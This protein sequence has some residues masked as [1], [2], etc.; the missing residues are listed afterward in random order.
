MNSQL[1]SRQ[2]IDYLVSRW[3]A[4]PRGGGK[5][6]LRHEVVQASVVASVPSVFTHAVAI[7]SSADF[8]ARGLEPSKQLPQRSPTLPRAADNRMKSAFQK[9]KSSV[10]RNRKM[11]V[12]TGAVLLSTAAVTAVAFGSI[13]ATQSN[14]SVR[15]RIIP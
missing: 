15:I 5:D 13:A 4:E 7:D 1:V 11:K 10:D 2:K 6:R 3:W 14:L 12:A 9:N 8:K